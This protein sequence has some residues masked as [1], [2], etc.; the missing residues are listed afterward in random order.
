MQ[1]WLLME[2]F[3]LNSSTLSHADIVDALD[4]KCCTII[5]DHATV[6]RKK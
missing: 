5:E 3:P 4:S 2:E 6:L 1:D